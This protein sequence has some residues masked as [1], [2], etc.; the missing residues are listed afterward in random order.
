MVLHK[1]KLAA[2]ISSDISMVFPFNWQPLEGQDKS[3]IWMF[4]SKECQGRAA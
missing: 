2:S 4:D 1:R 3:L